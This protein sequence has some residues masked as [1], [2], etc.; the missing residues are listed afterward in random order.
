MI[1][2]Q[3][4][5]VTRMNKFVIIPTKQV[6]NNEASATYKAAIS[7]S[8][9]TYQLVSSNNHRKN[10]AEKAIQNWK[11]HFVAVLSGIAD[12]FPLN[13]WCQLIPHM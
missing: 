10:I 12:N 13:M 5:A 9:M 7:E 6:L 2:A 8:N 1:Q 11:D 3:S 4:Q